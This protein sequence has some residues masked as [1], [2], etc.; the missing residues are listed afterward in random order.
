MS[1]FSIPLT[2]LESSQT[3][4]NTIANNISNMNTT[5]FKSQNANFS[6]LFYQELG[7]TGSGNLIEVGA[8]TKVSSTATDFTQGTINSTGSAEDV[9]I[10]GN[11]FFVVQNNSGTEYTRNGSFTLDSNGYLVTQSGQQVMGYAASNGVVNTNGALSAMQIPVGAVEQPSASSA[12]SLSANL[13]STVAVGDTYSAPITLYDSLG[14]SY[15]ATV[16]FTKT[17]NQTWDYSIALPSGDATGGSNLTGTLTFDANGNLSSPA[18][19]VSGITFTGLSDGAS[20]MN[21]TWNLYSSSGAGT[22]TQVDSSSSVSSTTQNGYA[23]G[24][25]KSFAIDSDGV[26]TVSYNNGETATIGQLALASVTNLQ[27]LKLGADGNYET[28]IASGTASIGVAGSGGRG[29]IEDEAL[30]GSN[31]DISTEFS[32]LIEEQQAFGASSKAITTFDTLAQET[33]NMIH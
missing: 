26:I 2:G 25:Y 32:K 5:A 9:A 6:D 3:A 31:V 8:G 11:G 33:I 23:S 1:S 28:T 10:N 12:M 18:A 20:D 17:A 14:T 15:S 22:I 30:E 19:N 29:T 13:D 21:L 16:T 27:G 4:L 7:T 24:T